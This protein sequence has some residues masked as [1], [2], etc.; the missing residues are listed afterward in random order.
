[1]D[2]F[3]VEGTLGVNDYEANDLNYF[4]NP[5]TKE[6]NLSS[7]KII[8]GLEIYN[9]LGQ[10]IISK[11]EINSNNHKI[12]LSLISQSVYIVNVMIDNKTERF[13]LQIN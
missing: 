5:T 2:S 13:K 1:M 9:L 4:F 6:L 11:N 3:V 12:N 7:T 8:S 10:K